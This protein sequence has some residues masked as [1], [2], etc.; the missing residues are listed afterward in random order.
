MKTLYL[1]SLLLLL[2]CGPCDPQPAD[3]PSTLRCTPVKPG[4]DLLC[5]PGYCYDPATW[6]CVV[7]P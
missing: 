2:A 5:P 4:S 6:V 1:V 7:M 3:D